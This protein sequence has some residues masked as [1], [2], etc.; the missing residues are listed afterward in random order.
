MSFAL[1]NSVRA[2]ARRPA[3]TRATL[4][5]F[6]TENTALQKYLETDKA[7]AHHAARE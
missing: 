1:R 6:T 3:S 4:R 7:L 2:V 5:T